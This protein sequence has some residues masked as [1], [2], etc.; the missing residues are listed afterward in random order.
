MADLTGSGKERQDF[1]KK[2]FEEGMKEISENPDWDGFDS[3][4]ERLELCGDAESLRAQR[5]P[6]ELL[7]PYLDEEELLGH[8]VD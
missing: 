6:E 7:V 5:V 1:S 2:W 3:V 8:K 4:K